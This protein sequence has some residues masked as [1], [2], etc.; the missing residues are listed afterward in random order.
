MLDLLKLFKFEKKKF[1]SKNK[2]RLQ[3]IYFKYLL[4]F[5]YSVLSSYC[6]VLIGI[7]YTYMYT[8]IPI[9]VCLCYPYSILIVN[10]IDTGLY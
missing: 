9:C 10:S 1:G 4:F 6:L 2:S 3:N 5:Q 8:L 7:M